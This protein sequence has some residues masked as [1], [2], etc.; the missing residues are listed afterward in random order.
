M[1]NVSGRGVGMD[2]VKTAIEELRGAVE[3]ASVPGR[4]TRITLRL[5][6]TLA[7]IDGLLVR[8]GAGMFVIPLAA[9]EECVELAATEHKGSSGRS[10]L[11]IR[12]GLVPFLRLHDLFALDAEAGAEMVVIVGSD[13]GRVGLVVD[14]VV[15][16]HQTVIKPLSRLHRG[17]TGLARRHHPGRRP[18]GADPRRDAADRLRPGAR[19][20]AALGMSARHRGAAMPAPPRGSVVA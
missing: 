15:G 5:P 14:Q 19:R 7:I 17:I 6:L 2:V 13:H 20:A 11:N 12:G 10:F 1:T 8:V 9:V 3:V 4:G 16:H 18:G